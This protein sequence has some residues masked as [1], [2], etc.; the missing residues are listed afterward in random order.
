[1]N[2][3]LIWCAA[4]LALAGACAN[5]DANAAA[6]E[7]VLA[8]SETLHAKHGGAVFTVSNESNGNRVIAFMRDDDGELTA[9][10][11]IATQGNGSGDSLGSQGALVLSED[12]RFLLVVNAGSN[13]VSSFA[14]EGAQLKLVDRVASGGIRPI[15]VTT[16]RGLAYVL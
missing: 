4:M 10:G 9:A 16:R 3:S 13:D 11:A 6:D 15:S 12:P 7:D 2:R 1:M 14:V 8:T 5:S